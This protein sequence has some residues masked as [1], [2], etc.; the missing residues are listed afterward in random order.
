MKL[1]IDKEMLAKE[2][3]N[4]TRGILHEVRH[5]AELPFTQDILE[6]A[7]PTIETLLKSAASLPPR[8]SLQQFYDTQSDIAKANKG[9]RIPKNTEDP[10]L[11]EMWEVD[12]EVSK[13][14]NVGKILVSNRKEVKGRE[15]YFNLFELLWNGTETYVAPVK[16][17]QEEIARLSRQKNRHGVALINVHNRDKERWLFMVHKYK[18]VRGRGKTQKV[19]NEGMKAYLSGE[20]KPEPRKKTMTDMF[21]NERRENVAGSEAKTFGSE[22]FTKTERLGVTAAGLKKMARKNY[23][24]QKEPTSFQKRLSSGKL[25]KR[26][27]SGR[28]G[29]RVPH[30]TWELYDIGGEDKSYHQKIAHYMHFYNRFKGAFYVN[31]LVRKGIEGQVLE[32]FHEYVSR[33]IL[34]GLNIAMGQVSEETV[35]D[36]YNASRFTK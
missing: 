18:K 31:Q 7:A 4:H 32:D 20:V 6:K 30:L 28:H 15:A 1:E 8:G 16:L 35:E 27:Y 29:A 19:Y 3:E 24:M 2:L 36:I 34:N 13:R 23:I 17:N 25:G 21:A 26:Q 5:L 33:C 9:W 14:D 22:D 11:I 12:W 10:H